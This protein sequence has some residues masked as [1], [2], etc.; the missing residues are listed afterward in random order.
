[1][2]EKNYKTSRRESRRQKTDYHR[3]TL[4]IGLFLSIGL[5]LM[6][7]SWRTN[8]SAFYVW[9]VSINLATFALFA[10]DKAASKV[11]GAPRIP[12]TVLHAFTLL[13]GMVGQHFGRA[14]FHHKTNIRR[15]PSFRRIQVLSIL[16]WGTL[17]FRRFRIG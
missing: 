13:G 6:I 2:V 16:I 8:L 5:F 11:Q 14:L 3:I 4:G 7:L 10:G 1:M 15:H 17:V 9:L 12:E